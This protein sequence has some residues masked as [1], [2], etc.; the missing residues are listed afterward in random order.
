MVLKIPFVVLSVI[1]ELKS[2]TLGEAE[3]VGCEVDEVC[4]V[5][6]IDD[7]HIVVEV[8]SGVSSTQLNVEYVGSVV[9]PSCSCSSAISPCFF[10]SLL[11]QG[12]SSLSSVRLSSISTLPS[13]RV[14][15]SSIFSLVSPSW[16]N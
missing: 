9:L 15:A 3:D 5:V 6:N 13:L 7:G 2:D 12:A 10:L 14:A 8:S 16:F 4:E 11:H 1:A